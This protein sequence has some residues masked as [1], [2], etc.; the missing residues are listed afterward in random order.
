MIVRVDTLDDPRLDAYARLTDVQLRSRLEPEKGLFI[1][2]SGNVIERALEAGMQPLSL[3]MEEKWLDALRPVIER[4][5]AA[6]PDAPVFVAPRAELAKLTGFELTRGALAAFRRPALPSVADVVR[7][8]RRVAVLENVTNHT[9]VGAIFRSAAA[10][11]MDAVLVTPSCYDPLYR[12][13]VRVSMGTVFQI[14]WTR[15]GEDGEC[16]DPRKATSGAWATAG[17]P[18]LRE[19]G[20]ATA[21]FALSDDSVSLDDPR[22]AAEERLALVFGTEGDGLSP[23]TISGCDYTVR[24]PMQHGVDSLNVAAASA[25]AFWALRR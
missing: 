17:I 3:L 11:G 10:L 1:A 15:I 20:F 5:A 21:A 24:I 25:V 4:A 22:L 14:P 19:L 12:R 23:V 18:L 6:N 13:A 16:T 2:E 8:A 9:N 7:D